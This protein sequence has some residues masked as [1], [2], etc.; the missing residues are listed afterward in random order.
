MLRRRPLLIDSVVRSWHW[1]LL[2]VR[3]QTSV[4]VSC[5]DRNTSTSPFD[6]SETH[7]PTLPSTAR[8]IAQPWSRTNAASSSI[9]S[10]HRRRVEHERLSHPGRQRLPR[11]RPQRDC[12][13]F[14]GLAGVGYTRDVPAGI[15]IAFYLT[16]KSEATDIQAPR[17]PRPRALT[18]PRRAG[19]VHRRLAS[20]HLTYPTRAPT[21]G[22]LS[23]TI[24]H[25]R[26]PHGPSTGCPP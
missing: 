20:S 11:A 21:T 26:R 19:L 4:S 5:R 6:I 25:S 8:T 16:V 9:S 17:G 14:T 15:A 22:R 2:S 23:P 7:S 24:S 3:P 18:W 10:S 12:L 13:D 1:L